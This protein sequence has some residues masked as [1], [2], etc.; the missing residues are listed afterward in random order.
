[1][2]L[3]GTQAEPTVCGTESKICNVSRGGE[4]ALSFQNSC[5]LE[6]E[7]EYRVHFNIQWSLTY[8]I[9]SLPVFLY[10]LP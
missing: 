1:M 6:G 5:F 4:L 3:T 7:T 10:T 9:I 8:V 2:R